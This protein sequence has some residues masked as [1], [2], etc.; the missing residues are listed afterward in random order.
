MATFSLKDFIREARR[1]RVFRVTALYIVGAFVALQVADLAFPGLGIK[2]SA[3]LYVWIG[4]ILGL[5]IALFFGWRYD[6]IGGRIVRTAVSDVDANLSIERADYIILVALSVVVA[7][8]AFGLVG[9]IS[10]TRVPETTQFAVTDLDPNSI[11]VLPFVNMS[12]DPSNEYFADGISEDILNLLAKVPDLPVTSR[13]SAFSFKGQNLDVP[14][15]AAKLNVAHVLE[16]SVRKSGNELRIVAQLIEVETDTHLWSE[17]YDR[18]LKN[19]FAIQDDIAGAVV[20]ALKITLLGDK[21]KA[22][23]TNP[24]AYALYLQARYL[25]NQFTGEA[26]TRAETLLKRALEIDPGFAP[27]WY[28]LG[29][30][31]RYGANSRDLTFYEE[32]ELARQT[33]NKALDVDPQYGPAYAG[34]AQL[35]MEHDWDFAAARQHMQKALALDPG[36]ADILKNAAHL[37]RILGRQD[38]A[39]DLYRQ[40]AALDPLSYTTHVWLGLSHL[41]GGRLDEAADSAH[42]MLSLNPDG[43][44]AHYLLAGVL[45]RQGQA[46][47]ALAEIEREPADTFRLMGMAII[48]HHLGNAGASDAALKELIECCAADGDPPGSEYQI[49]VVCAIRGEIDHA[50]EWLEVAY[51]NRDGSLPMVM[52]SE[53]FTS[54]HDD[55]RWE[56][57]LDKMGLLH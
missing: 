7:A 39:T 32:Y 4:A 15:M 44:F 3:I 41:R 20:D 50:F 37:N 18:E 52:T 10:K 54:L 57:F 9:E 25:R 21:P 48:Q 42:M 43:V 22:T 6:I 56:A 33:I 2:E 1:R 51:D 40:A 35:E 27:A 19:V 45:R 16:G 30:G 31:Y 11:A 55:P 53:A 46:Q 47:A 29:M 14:T 23:E 26:R 28:L 49:A 24:E 5:P 13:S 36:D 12:D 8:I 34:L 17:T 38:E